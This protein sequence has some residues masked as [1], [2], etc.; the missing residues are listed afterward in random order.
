ML[1]RGAA[2]LVALRNLNLGSSRLQYS[3][4][5][6]LGITIHY[7]VVGRLIKGYPIMAAELQEDATTF[8]EYLV[9]HTI[10]RK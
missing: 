6:C 7:L 8:V 5:P 2:Y 10:N 1:K 9:Q 3:S 4:S